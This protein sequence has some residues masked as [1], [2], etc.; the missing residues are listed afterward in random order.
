MS[1]KKIAEKYAQQ[2]RDWLTYSVD[3]NGTVWCYAN[4]AEKM[5]LAAINEYRK[6]NK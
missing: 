3:E 5:I 1:R 4:N 2:I 6:E